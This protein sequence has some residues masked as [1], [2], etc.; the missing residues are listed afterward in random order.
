MRTQEAIKISI[1][2]AEMVVGA[3][4]G[5]L[6]DSDLMKRP[7]PQCNHINWQIGHLIVSENSML[8]NVVPGGMPPL[9]P[10]F[11]AMYSKE[12]AAND[13]P[14]K[15]ATKEQLMAA[16]KTQRQA[17]LNGLAKA[18]EEDLGKESGVSYAPTVASLYS[19]QGSHW[20]MHC[21][22]WVVVRRLLGKPVVM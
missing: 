4:L 18:S 19:M 5:D 2:T 3:Y 11:E 10:G 8:K 12:A 21:G 13:D 16:L 15:F 22:Q 14:S 6:S 20:L 9:P 17:T 1:E 7:H